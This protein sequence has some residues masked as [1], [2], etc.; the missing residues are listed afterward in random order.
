M[1]KPKW[2]S[3]FKSYV[4]I[5]NVERGISIFIR[6]PL[7]QGIMYDF[8]SSPD[9]KPS[10]FLKEHIIPYLDKYKNSSLAQTIISHP[11]T[12]HF[13]DIDC[14]FVPSVKGSPFFSSLHTCP[15]DKTDGTAKTEVINWERIKNPEGTDEKIKKYRSLFEGRFTPLQ[16]ILYDSTR[17]IPNLEYGLY[18]VRPPVVEE[19][20]PDNDQEYGN[21]VSL[22]IF[23][24]HGYHSLLIPGDINPDTFKHLLD[25][26]DGLEKRY[27]KFDK[28][29]SALHPDWHKASG[30]QPGL[31]DLLEY[32]GLSI[33]VAPHHGLESGYSEDLYQSI[34]DDR[35]G[36]V[37]ISEKRHKSETDGQV[38]PFYQSKDGAKGQDVYIEGNKESHY[39]VSTRNGHHILISFQG[40]GGKPKV[41]LEPDANTLLEKMD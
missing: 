37:V 17:S 36:L 21:G 13:T 27:T 18:Y 35:P 30:N 10:V 32:H 4:L 29:Q 40:T 22:V 34:K 16:T 6:T 3:S 38:D 33:L 15:H 7:N 8:G 31:K 9:F 14:L 1:T 41:Y 26:G 11:H 19:I 5:F 24:R 28:R 2:V 39:S 23:Y 12:D 20:Y 25:E